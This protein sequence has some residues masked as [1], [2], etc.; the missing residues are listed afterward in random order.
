M[1]NIWECSS[2]ASGCKSEGECEKC[3][4]YKNCQS[5]RNR[6]KKICTSCAN[7]KELRELKKQRLGSYLKNKSKLERMEEELQEHR[8]KEIAERLKA[9]KEGCQE[10]CEEII[11]EIEQLE[12]EEEKNVLFLRYILGMKWEDICIRLSVSWSKAHYIH[13][14][15]LINYQFAG[16][17]HIF[18]CDNA[19]LLFL[20]I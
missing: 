7:R 15:A 1:E 17:A 4:L 8:E 20:K 3:S 2:N 19:Q 11:M 16:D 6:E 10:T 5:C 18:L 9:W 14:R 13:K 12:N